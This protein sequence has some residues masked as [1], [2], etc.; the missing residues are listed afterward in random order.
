MIG[1]VGRVLGT[2]HEH[3]AVPRHR[4]ADVDRVFAVFEFLGF[5]KQVG[6]FGGR[7]LVDNQSQ[8]AFVFVTNQQNY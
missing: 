5:G 6:Q 3:H 4:A 7:G 1:L 8:R 2:E